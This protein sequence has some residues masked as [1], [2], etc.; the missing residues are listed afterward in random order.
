MRWRTWLWSRLL[1]MVD[2]LWGTQLIEREL[3]R[4]QHRIERLTA[5]MDAFNR[6][7][8]VLVAELT[9]HRLL[10]CLIERKARSERENL[11]DWLYFSPHTD[12]EESLL[13]SA[14]DCLVKP[15]LARIDVDPVGPREYVYRL[16]PDWAAIIDRLRGTAVAVGLM[17]WIEEQ[18]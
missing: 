14:I 4:R 17:T 9:L 2:R 10:L 18:V 7:L 8:E 15:R 5:D 1:L 11:D 6:E 3:G 12:G 13:D 16:Q